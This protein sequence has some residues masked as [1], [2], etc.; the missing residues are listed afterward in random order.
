MLT[1]NYYLSNETFQKEKQSFQNLWLFACFKQDLKNEGDYVL[2]KFPF[3]EVIIRNFGEKIKAF[4]N[5]CPH[6]FS[7]IFSESSGNSIL[8]CPYHG[9]RFNES[10]NPS[11]IPHK[12][13]CFGN[14]FDLEKASLKFLDID[15]CGEFV[16]L[17]AHKNQ[18]SITLEDFLGIDYSTLLK[19]SSFLSTRIDTHEYS[20]K[21][22]WKLVIENSLEEYHLL[23]VHP[24][25]LAQILS[26]NIKYELNPY[27]SSSTISL[28]EKNSNKLQK[29]KKFFTNSLEQADYKH[30]FI[31]PNLA[32]AT[33]EGFSFFIQEAWPLS[34]EETKYISHGFLPNFQ[35]SC[36]P[37]I[38]Q[39]IT[40]QYK[41]TNRKVFYEDLSIC[42]GIQI[43]LKTVANYEGILGKREERIHHFQ[44]LYLKTLE[45]S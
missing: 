43:A 24:E 15:Y 3:G 41:N 32:I 23:K 19:I 12:K 36:S 31:F 25:T 20:F 22:N 34:A 13:D 4:F 45:T 2:K 28:Q 9:W 11:V 35:T 40:E 33:T 37:I 26:N 29:I 27:S 14:E 16:F 21:A 39:Q 44:S 1:S 10:G 6:R 17:R 18:H 8:E 30:T 5:I 7:R 38:Q 42:D